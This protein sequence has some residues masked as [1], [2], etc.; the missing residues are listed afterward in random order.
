MNKN[1]QGGTAYLEV[2]RMEVEVLR[3]RFERYCASDLGSIAHQILGICKDLSHIGKD[4]FCFCQICVRGGLSP[5][6]QHL[7]FLPT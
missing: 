7:T 2:L 5:N 4:R 6:A 1:K 3:I